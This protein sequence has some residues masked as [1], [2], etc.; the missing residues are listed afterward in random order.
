MIKK[1]L[2]FLLV[3]LS[4]GYIQSSA[5]A[6]EVP[7]DIFKD[8]ENMHNDYL[9]QRIDL[10]AAQA[11]CQS[12]FAYARARNIR[13]V[14]DG[15]DGN[16]YVPY[17]QWCEDSDFRIVEF[18]TLQVADFLK[19]WSNESYFA[20]MVSDAKMSCKRSAQIQHLISQQYA[21]NNNEVTVKCSHSDNRCMISM[22]VTKSGTTQHYTACCLMPDYSRMQQ[23]TE[24][25]TDENGNTGTRTY[26]T[27]IAGYVDIQWNGVTSQIPNIT[28]F[29][30]KCK[31]IQNVE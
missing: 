4:G 1:L 16:Q 12:M 11:I 27:G 25:I 10:A 24:Q 29:D 2:L 26:Y 30:L 3:L 31:P 8:A 20:K 9:A 17:V 18:L 6:D 15:L 22:P 13:I 21:V 23:T 7:R 5:F 14:L 28:D 19:S